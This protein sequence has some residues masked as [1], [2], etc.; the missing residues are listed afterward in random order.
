MSCPN[1][2]GTLVST[3][4]YEVCEKCGHVPPEGAD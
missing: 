2:S 4:N 1:C 3:N